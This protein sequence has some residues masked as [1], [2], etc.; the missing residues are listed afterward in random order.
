MPVLTV[1]QLAELCGGRAEGNTRIEIHAANA[2]E[3]AEPTQLGFVGNSRNAA[4][5]ETSQAGCLLVPLEFDNSSGRTIVRV[6]NPRTAF[7][8]AIIVLHPDQTPVSA[9]H[10]TA[11][12]CLSAQIG[13]DCYIGPNVVIGERVV[14]G[15]KCIIHAGCVLENDSILGNDCILHP[16]VT[17]YPKIHIGNSVILHA[18]CVIGADGFGFAFNG[19][20]YEKFP[21]IGN[22]EI[23]DNVELG[24]NTCVDRAALGVTYIGEGTKLDNLVHVAHNCRIGKHVV[25]AAQTG[26][27]GSVTIGDYAVLAGQVGIAD[28]ATIHAKSILGAQAGVLSSK[29]V[30]ESEPLWGTPAR[31]L[32]EYLRQLAALRRLPEL[33]KEMKELRARLEAMEKH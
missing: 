20:H 8:R 7:A 10:P 29:V 1:A 6:Q 16:N 9:I 14:I 13:T 24:A 11:S 15:N 5:A 25:I 21:Q 18:G 32:K 19:A 17:I 2:L 30:R 28:K 12:I 23:A 3:T 26:L 22:V 27:S 33:F 4:A 31:P